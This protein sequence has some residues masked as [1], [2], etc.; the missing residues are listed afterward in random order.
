MRSLALG[1]VF[2]ADGGT[3]T[4]LPLRSRTSNRVMLLRGNGQADNPISEDTQ[5]GTF[6]F[7]HM[8]PKRMQLHAKPNVR[9][10]G[11][12]V[13]GSVSGLPVIRQGLLLTVFQVGLRYSLSDSAMM[14]LLTTR[15]RLR[16]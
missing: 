10:L 2:D 8:V 12:R 9:R 15:G 16:D 13:V 4:T 11:R 5:A 7:H 3:W 1:V 14:Y 6:R